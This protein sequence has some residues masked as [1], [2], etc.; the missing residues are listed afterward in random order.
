MRRPR[1][2]TALGPMTAIRGDRLELYAWGGLS[3]SNLLALLISLVGGLA[4][5]FSPGW[6]APGVLLLLLFGYSCVIVFRSRRV[7]IAFREGDVLINHERYL[8][9]SV[10]DFQGRRIEEPSG[11]HPTGAQLWMRLSDGRE[12]PLAQLSG[13]AQI[14]KIAEYLN[15]RLAQ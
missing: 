15:A 2:G 13:N 8:R 11:N 4:C 14:E 7:R 1:L 6:R 12:V 3:I 10:A 9:K 5:L